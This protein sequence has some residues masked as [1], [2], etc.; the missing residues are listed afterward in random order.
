MGVPPELEAAEYVLDFIHLGLMQF[1]LVQADAQIHVPHQ[2]VHLP[3]EQDLVDVVPQGLALFPADFVGVL[4]DAGQSPVFLDPLGRITIPHSGDPGDV[5]RLFPPHGGQIRVLPGGHFVFG[6]DGVRGH[7][8]QVLEMMARVQDGDGIIHQL[9]GVSVSGEDE[10]LEPRFLPHGRQSGD[11]VIPFEPLPFHIRDVQG[12]EDF[13]DEG[14][15]AQQVFRGRVPGPFVLGQHL[16]AESAAFHVEGDGHMTG[17]LI[18][19]D[20]GQHGS[21]TVDGIGRLAV[22]SAEAVGGQS[23]IGAEGQGMP[24]DD[25]EPSVESAV[26]G[27]VRGRGFSHGSILKASVYQYGRKTQRGKRGPRRT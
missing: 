12:L 1:E 16:I 3:V 24:V 11:D 20:L 5:V 17:F 13:L 2:G 26:G 27:I 10:G 14:E 22:G 8:L 15:L 23:E 9:E 21:E 19:Q 18:P 6:E 4:H 25:Q 7:M